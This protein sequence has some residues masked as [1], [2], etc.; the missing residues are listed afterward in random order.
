MMKSCNGQHLRL[1]RRTME[2]ITSTPPILAA[3]CHHSAINTHGVDIEDE[4]RHGQPLGDNAVSIRGAKQLNSCA[5]G[6]CCQCA[7]T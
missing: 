5:N 6:N 7:W 4:S 1:V 3:Y 2:Y